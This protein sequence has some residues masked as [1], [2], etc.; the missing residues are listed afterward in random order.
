M[1]IKYVIVEDFMNYKKPALFIGTAFCDF[2]C[3][4]ECGI[5]CCHNNPLINEPIIDIDN[6]KLV[7]IYLNNDITKSIVIGGLEPFLQFDEMYSLI[8]YFREKTNDEIIIYTGYYKEEILN[9]IEELKRFE[10]IIIK[11]GRFIPN[12]KSVYDEV[13]GI[14]LASENQYAEKIS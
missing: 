12:N 11:F 1:R 9:Y 13:L 10:N 8:K 4:K 5:A 7:D 2:K 3:E 14:E 6:S